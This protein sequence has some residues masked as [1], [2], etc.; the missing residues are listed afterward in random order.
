M[1]TEQ[2]TKTDT[3]PGLIADRIVTAAALLDSLDGQMQSPH[4]SVTDT[5]DPMVLLAL[6]ER[7]W[8]LYRITSNGNRWFAATPAEFASHR[9][10]TVNWFPHGDESAAGARIEKL[11]EAA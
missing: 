1:H 9:A 6:H 5:R 7:G 10:H 8:R 4:A 11:A 3:D 2:N